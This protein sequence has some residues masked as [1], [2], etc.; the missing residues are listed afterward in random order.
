[1]ASHWPESR[2]KNANGIIPVMTDISNQRTISETNEF[3]MPASDDSLPK[4]SNCRPR[5]RLCLIDEPI[6]KV[7]NIVSEVE[8]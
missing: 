2:K 8:M 3:L 4:I 6:S 1:M 7:L 5:W